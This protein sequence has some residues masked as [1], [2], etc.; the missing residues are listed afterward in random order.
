MEMQDTKKWNTLPVT[1]DER[2]YQIK[3]KKENKKKNP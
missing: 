2:K 1:Y 3:E